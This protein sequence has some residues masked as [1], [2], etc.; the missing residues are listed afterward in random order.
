MPGVMGI[1]NVTPDSFF[2][3]QR[4]ESVDAAVTRGTLLF[5]QGAAIVD[6]GGESTRPGAT[7][8]SEVDEL[9]R[10]VAVVAALSELGP[11]SIDTTKEEVAR[12]CVAAGAVMINDVGGR[13][14]PVAGELGV[15]WVAMHAKGTPQTMQDD[16]RYDDVVEEVRDWLLAKIGEA[17]DVGVTD[18]WIDPGIGFGKTAAHNWT[19]LR[20]CDE[21]ASLAAETETRL[22]VGTSRKRFLGMLGGEE[23]PVNERLAAS[24]ATATA[25]LEAGAALVRVHDVAES[26]EATKLLTEELIAL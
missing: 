14:A 15:A 8:V 9:A 4:T 10:V 6:V 19:L 1:V 18:V 24:V 22:L 11:V 12:Q 23:R 3:E 5:A 21:F 26:V 17:R 2:A 13:L 16:P 7:P 25:A 20:H